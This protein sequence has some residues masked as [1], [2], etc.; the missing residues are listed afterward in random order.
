M[1][2]R[3]RAKLPEVKAEAPVV[4]EN[5]AADEQDRDT[6]R[7]DGGDSYPGHSEREADN[8]QQI[9]DDVDAAGY[10]KNQERMA[11]VPVRP[12]NARA[13]VVDDGEHQ[14]GEVDS[15]IDDRFGVNLRRGRRQTDELRRQQNAQN[16]QAHPQHNRKGEG[17]PNRGA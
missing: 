15:E 2:P 3:Q 13:D 4:P 17:N 7:N 8:K 11:G 6:L 1:M 14:S 10:Q 9:E 16:R 5:A 12:Q